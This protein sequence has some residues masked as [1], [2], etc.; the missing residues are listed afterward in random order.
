MR[1]TP[2]VL[3]AAVATASPTLSKRELARRQ[4]AESCSIGYCTENGGTTGGA[5]GDTVEVSDLDAL[6]EAAESEDPLTIIVTGDI[7]G[8]AKIRVGSDK[9]IY[10]ES[11]AS[12]YSIT[13]NTSYCRESM[14]IVRSHHRCGL[15]H[16]PSQQRY[17]P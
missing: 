4:A 11:G 14:L 12:M 5:A 13:L 16:P 1:F 6:T 3:L 15:L 2:I 10:G 17:H 7:S 9:T 8:S